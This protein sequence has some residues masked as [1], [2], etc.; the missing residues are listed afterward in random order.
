MNAK[1]YVGNLSF[2]ATENDLIDLFS[3]H[4]KVDDARLILDAQT[5]RPR[6]FGFITMSTPEEAQRAAEALH[7]SNFLG[8]TLKVNE[9][10]PPEKRQGAPHHGNGKPRRFHHHHGRH[11]NGENGSQENE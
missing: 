2:S 9:A 3:Q 6:G 8:R 5:R 7:G 1:L 10:R 4:G 11:E